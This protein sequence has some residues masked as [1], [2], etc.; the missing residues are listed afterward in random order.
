MGSNPQI[1]T[2]AKVETTPGPFRLIPHSGSDEFSVEAGK[3]QMVANF[4]GAGPA[5]KAN[6]LI[7]MN[8]ASIMAALKRSAQEHLDMASLLDAWA[9]ESVEG[10]WS[11]HQVDAQRRR[12]DQCRKYAADA[13]AAIAKAERG[14]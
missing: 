7:N 13:L 8:A 6:A 10:S 11:T 12:A 1:E 2:P 3:G 5:N 4:A 9:R 14:Q